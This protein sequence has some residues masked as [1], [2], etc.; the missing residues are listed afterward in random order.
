MLSAEARINGR[1]YM[2]A[3]G[4]TEQTF[5]DIMLGTRTE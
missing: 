3:E 4:Q 1:L 2:F 5:A